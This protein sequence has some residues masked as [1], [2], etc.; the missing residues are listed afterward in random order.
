MSMLSQSKHVSTLQ[1]MKQ[2]GNIR[3]GDSRGVIAF[4]PMHMC[5]DTSFGISQQDSLQRDQMKL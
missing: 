3:D 4:N 1:V 2:A 5:T